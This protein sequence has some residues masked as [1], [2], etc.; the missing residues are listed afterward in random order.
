MMIR[1]IIDS[2]KYDA[3]EVPLFVR[4]VCVLKNGERIVTHEIPAEYSPVPDIY[5]LKKESSQQERILEL[6]EKVTQKKKK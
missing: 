3:T 6:A 1:K 2:R 4:R 5:H